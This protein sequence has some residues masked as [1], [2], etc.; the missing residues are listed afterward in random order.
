VLIWDGECGFCRAWAEAAAAKLPAGTEV[1]PWQSIDDLSAY[2]LTE[3][4]VRAAV[5][6]WDGTRAWAGE[7]AVARALWATGGPWAALGLVLDLPPVRPLAAA[8]YRWIADN[9]QRLPAPRLPHRS[10][11]G[12]LDRP[13]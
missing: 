10:R 7:R 13:V 11:A 12:T 2:G 1:V 8:G 4:D 9:R 3:A 6:W 5:Q